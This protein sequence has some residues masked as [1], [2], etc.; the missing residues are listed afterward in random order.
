MS[1]T[2]S[3]VLSP[4]DLLHNTPPSCTTQKSEAAIRSDENMLTSPASYST[5]NATVLSPNT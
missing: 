3:I 5:V 4:I 1:V 2:E